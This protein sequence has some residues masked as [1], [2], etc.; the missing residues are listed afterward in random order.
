MLRK[1]I[2]KKTNKMTGSVGLYARNDF[3]HV[4][5]IAIYPDT[6]GWSPKDLSP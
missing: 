4:G 5:A 1:A 2:L 6:S 3:G